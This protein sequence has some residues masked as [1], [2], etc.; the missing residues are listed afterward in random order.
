MWCVTRVPGK[1]DWE[2]GTWV[3]DVS[4]LSFAIVGPSEGTH[5]N[6]TKEGYVYYNASTVFWQPAKQLHNICYIKIFGKIFLDHMSPGSVH[7]HA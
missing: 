6:A 2:R 1:G 4:C 5:P 7:D 3:L